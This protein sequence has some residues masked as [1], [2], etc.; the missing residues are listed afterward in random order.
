MDQK[1]QKSQEKNLSELMEFDFDDILI[2][3][4][5][6]EQKESPSQNAVKNGKE[7]TEKTR[8]SAQDKKK[9]EQQSKKAKRKKGLKIT[10]DIATWVKDLILAVL[11][12]W[13]LVTF[14]ATSV[15][16]PD[17]SMSPALQQNEHFLV[18]KL[19]YRFKEPDR[20]DILLFKCENAA[21]EQ[22]EAVSRVIGVPGD[23][24]VIDE[25]GTVTVNGKVLLTSYCNGTTLFVPNQMTYPYTVPNDYYFVLSD[26][27]NSRTDSRYS[28]IGAVAK[29]DIIG[30]V[31]VCW[32]PKESW[33]P[34]G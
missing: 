16:M 26:N 34:I 2:D 10:F 6:G 5:P 12:L 25:S 17:Q 13:I 23:T 20:G 4:L 19:V 3:D 9:Q 11:V 27:P 14:V 24:I 31:F 22:Q 8:N 1:D 32:W 7:A 33:R 21:G 18:S 15:Q 29:S 30:R 28:A